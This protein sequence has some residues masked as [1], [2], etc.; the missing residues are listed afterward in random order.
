[1]CWHKY[2]QW[3]EVRRG[4]VIAKDPIT[5]DEREVGHFLI[6]ERTCEKCGYIQI[7]EQTIQ[8]FN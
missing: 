7:K 4:K 8:S 3:K 2:G 6:Q 5:K 1:M